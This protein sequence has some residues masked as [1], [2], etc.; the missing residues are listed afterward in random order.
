MDFGWGSDS[1]T[2]SYGTSDLGYPDFSMSRIGKDQTSRYALQSSTPAM[3]F[4]L[5]P[6]A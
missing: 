5:S 6:V 1:Y 2:T 4:R 3:S